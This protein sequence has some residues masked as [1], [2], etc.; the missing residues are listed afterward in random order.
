VNRRWVIPLL[1]AAAIVVALS[2]WVA[3]ATGRRGALPPGNYTPREPP[4]VRLIGQQADAARAD[5]LRRAALR[6]GAAD[7]ALVGSQFAAEDLRDDTL[8][9]RFVAEDP[10]GTT[11]KFHCVVDGGEIVKV[12]YGRNA[13]IH[14]EAAATRLLSAVGFPA[15]RV[16]IVPRV[17]CYGCPRLPFETELVASLLPGKPR[18]GARDDTRYSEFTLAAVERRFPAPAIET[19]H[20]EG[21]AWWEMKQSTA[22]RADLDAL[23]LLAAFLA[24]WDNKSENQRLVCLDEAPQAA[25]AA[26]ARPLAMIQDLGATFG[27]SKVNLARWRETPVW[28]DARTCTLSMRLLPYGGGTF[29]DV[30]ISEAGRMQ[31]AQRLAAFSDADIRALFVEAHFPQFYSSTPDDRDLTAWTEAFRR[32]VDQIVTAGPC[33]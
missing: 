25:G 12:K 2:T 4:V 17:R 33:A 14:A 29:P 32:R 6:L 24:H 3:A 20:T 19:E 27:P 16:V 23:R 28:S 21:W 15:D 8:T 30:R 9:C 26:C 11:P 1:V 22:P 7:A 5:A 10:T 18:V 31:L 13:E